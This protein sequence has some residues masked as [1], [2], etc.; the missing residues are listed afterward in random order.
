ME[1]QGPGKGFLGSAGDPGLRY[2]S[3]KKPWVLRSLGLG[4]PRKVFR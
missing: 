3:P 1:Q 4:R 2:D